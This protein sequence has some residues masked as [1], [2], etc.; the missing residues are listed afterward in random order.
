M[1]YDG[2][3]G[4]CHAFREFAERRDVTGQ[5]E[6]IPFQTAELERIAPGLTPELASEAV[7]LVREDGRRFRGAR[8]VFEVMRRWPGVWG[9]LGTMMAFPPLSL[10]AEPFYRL[11]ARHRT[12]ISHWLRL[13]RC[14]VVSTNE[15]EPPRNSGAGP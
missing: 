11:F 9:I 6:F 14:A 13:E 12:R 7:Y 8:A 3:C 5:L 1:I 2:A 4:V 10:L 15:R